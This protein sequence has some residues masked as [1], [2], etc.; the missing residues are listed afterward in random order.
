MIQ[1]GDRVRHVNQEFDNK[2]GVM[3]VVEIRKLSITFA[4]C[5][6]CDDSKKYL[7][8]LSELKLHNN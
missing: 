1:E 7:F 5:A 2:I 6:C 3:E 4:V 8:P